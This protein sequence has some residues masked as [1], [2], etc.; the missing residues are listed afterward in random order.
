MAE[1]R[2]GDLVLSQGT[3]VLLQD[4]ATGQVEVVTG[5]FKV[6][7][8]DT[9][10]PVVYDRES[11]LFSP[12]TADKAI[13]VCPAAD[14]GQ[15]L[16]LTNPSKDDN[17]V[18]H[19]GKGKQPS[20]ELTMGRK[21]NLQGPT[22]FSLF[23]GQ[24]A[25][26]VDGH[27][28]KSNE[29]LLIR[30]YNEK[31][32]KENLKNSVVKTAE[33][34]D[35][36]EKGKK[37]ELF[38][39]KEIRTGNLLIIKGTD[40]SF[41]MPPTGIEVLEEKG[42]YTRDA[43]TLERL[44]YCILLD[45]N[46]DKRYVKGP[47]VVF[48]KPTEVF[49]QNKNQNV[50]RAIELN[51]AMGIYIKVIADYE[52]DKKYVAGEELFITGNEQKI[53]F[54]RAEH[55]IIKYGSETIHYAVAVPA[56]EGRYIL[57]KI[58]GDVKLVRGP[59]MLLPDPRKEVIVKR[60]LND[61]TVSLWYPGNAEALKYNQKLR[62]TLE[63]SPSGEYLEDLG[64][65][66]VKGRGSVK[67]ET[68]YSSAVAG[69]MDDEMERK[70]EFTKPRTIKLDTKYDGAVLLNIWPN[71][72]VQVVNKTGDRKVVEG[73]KVIMLEYDESLE[74]L[75]LSTGKPK[76][77]HTLIKTTYL[78][79]KN[80]VV[81]DIVTVETK[82]LIPVDVRLSYKVDF[83]ADAKKWFNVS[84][85]V[86]LLT[87][88]M[89]SLIRNV[90]KK[91]TVQEFN[92]KAADIIRDVILGES[93]EGK[94]VGRKFEEN[95]MKIYDVEVLD[96]AIGDEEIASM[97]VQNQHD[98]VEGNLQ[99][100]KLAKDL[101]FS[102]ISEELSR[103]KLDEQ[104]K[105][106]SKKTEVNLAE[107]L[108]DNKVTLL[109]FN[110][111]KDYE[112]AKAN[113]EKDIQEII[114]LI[115]ES[116]MG[117]EQRAED[118]KLGYEKERSAI[119]IEEVKEEMAAITPGLIEAIVSTN[120]VNLAEI[121]AKNLKEQKTGFSLGDL[122]GKSGGFEGLLETV[123]GTP[124]YDRLQQIHEDYKS[125]KIKDPEKKTVRKTKSSI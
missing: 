14:E 9:D 43:V 71:F 57:D 56:G 116:K 35:E 5:P 95:G 92:D 76:T 32:A 10:K 65:H 15:Y 29:Y 20:M 108:N 115:V 34:G 61:N 28:L 36:K 85:Y 106:H 16:I 26:V 109:K 103:Q 44:E 75:E 62:S 41:Y 63:S 69:Y 22:V 30:V 74:V 124:L 97:L 96:V 39:E 123:K 17:G 40:V 113:A 117:R 68:L 93:K 51:E 11:R 66:L 47:D 72:A 21:V 94:R 112:T 101:E 52:E 107:E 118:L 89:R 55:A 90:A 37:K 8:A 81:S 23:P 50:F 104:L 25:E 83:E 88:H 7:L 84:D 119:H 49:I 19:P 45:Q 105:T 91:A 58:K 125:M 79:T 27:Q 114:D 38:D 98:I 46:G 64:E 54:P 53:Y 12:T 70:T 67:K 3:Y 33:G 24:V 99:V 120:D 110:N 80:N 4:G 60:V 2:S 42:K 87:Q 82:D 18:K 122:F 48:P 6:S 59:K 121:L 13:R 31:E 86:K 77:D 78:Q 100:L 111:Q 1:G 102:K 73:P